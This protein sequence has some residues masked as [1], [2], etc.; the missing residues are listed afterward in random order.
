MERLWVLTTSLSY[1]RPHPAVS[2][3]LPSVLLVLILFSHQWADARLSIAR[4]ELD[5][6]SVTTALRE[7]LLTKLYGFESFPLTFHG[8]WNNQGQRKQHGD[9]TT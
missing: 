6:I 2:F 5:G 9:E 8:P 7:L 4:L 1:S 3:L